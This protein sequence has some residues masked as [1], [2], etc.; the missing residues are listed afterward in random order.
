MS[1]DYVP[2]QDE[3]TCTMTEEVR[4]GQI[5]KEV[6]PRFDR[7]LRIKAT[8]PVGRF[9][10]VETVEKFH[11]GWRHKHGT[12]TTNPGLD[13]FNGKRGGYELVVDKK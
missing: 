12:R 5:W 4:V 2:A 3:G 9:C 6:D 11:G 10:T 13:R 8:Y 1:G 7:F